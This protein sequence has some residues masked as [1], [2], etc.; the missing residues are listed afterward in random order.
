MKLSKKP[1]ACETI[2][3]IREAI[4]QLDLEII[5]LF[6]LRHEYVK[7]I[8]KF[9]S[10]DESIVANDRREHVLTQRKAWAEERGL[11]PEMMEEIFR[12][13]IEKNIQIQFDIYNKED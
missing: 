5:Q 8:V 9:K 3:E 4:D 10:G 2:D 11:D 13:L 1:Q 6:S 7:E 12:L